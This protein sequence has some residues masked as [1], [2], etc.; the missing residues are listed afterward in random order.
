VVGTVA[1]VEL[2]QV[3]YPGSRTQYTLLGRSL[4]FHFGGLVAVNLAQ[5]FFL[6]R[7]THNAPDDRSATEVPVLPEGSP[8]QLIAVDGF[9]A[10]GAAVSQTVTLVLAEDLTVLG[11]VLARTGDVASG[12]VTQVGAGGPGDARSIALQ[13]VM[14]RAGNVNVPLRGSQVR[15]G[16]GPVQ[17]KK[18]PESGKVEVT[19]FVAQSVQFP[20]E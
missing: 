6:K 2:A 16:A 20:N 13:R 18:L 8:V 19:L 10:E 9:S 3:Y 17:Y 1:A 12:Q 11:K 14:L 15:G 4:M 5:E 7:L